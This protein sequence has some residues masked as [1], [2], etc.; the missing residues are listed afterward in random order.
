VRADDAADV[1]S[2]VAASGVAATLLCACG[3]RT[4]LFVLV[5]AADAATTPDVAV[6]PPDV[7]DAGVPDGPAVCPDGGAPVAYV[8]SQGG[9]LYTFDPTTLTETPLGAVSCP[10]TA[11][12]WTFSVSRD[13]FALMIYEDW[14]IYR[15]ELPSLTCTPTAYVPGQLGFTGEEAIAVSRGPT[16]ERLFVYGNNGTPTLAVSDLTTFVLTEVGPVMSAPAPFP[17]DMQGDAFGRL[18][19]LSNGGLLLELD[20]ATAGVVV[21]DQTTFSSGFWAVMTYESSVYFF[22]SNN[23]GGTAVSEVD[24]STGALTPA[25][26][27]GDEIIGASAV[28]CT[29]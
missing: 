14:N 28:A 29:R 22:G 9:L 3:G 25:G 16:S 6:N 5:P 23:A 1:T 12:P 18:F 17:V 8:W 19:A 24:V 27:I 11:S 20:S 13:G 10:T 26:T 7:A 15:V 2:L 21:Q 4:E